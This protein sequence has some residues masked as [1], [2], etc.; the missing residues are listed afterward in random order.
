MDVIR[1][2]GENDLDARQQLQAELDSA[3]AERDGIEK[4]LA[5]DAERIA[6]I[7]VSLDSMTAAVWRD[8][9][10][11]QQRAKRHDVW[12]AALKLEWLGSWQFPAIGILLIVAISSTMALHT[13]GPI[14]STFLYA[15]FLLAGY[16]TA[17]DQCLTQLKKA[18]R[19]YLGDDGRD[20]RFVAF[21]H[22]ESGLHHPL[23]G[24]DGP[25]RNGSFEDRAWKIPGVR[26]DEALKEIFIEVIDDRHANVLLTRF[27]DKKPTLV[28]ADLENPF[29]RAYG[30][31]FQ[32]AL[33][34]QMPSVAAK[35]E[36][37][38]QT[39]VRMGE[40]KKLAERVGAI[41]RELR[42]LDGTQAVMSNMPVSL[43]VRNKLLGQTVFFRMGDA[44][45]GRG[46][47]LF[48][49]AGFDVN[50][51]VETIARASAAT[52]IPFSFSSQKIGYVG[53]GAAQVARTFE[54]A[55][56]ARSII[57]IEDGDRLFNNT[58]ATGFEP[59]RREVQQ[60]FLQQ[61]DALED[62]ADVWLIAAVHDR[63]AI[64][65]TVLAHFGTLI[66]LTPHA[67]SEQE[68]ASEAVPDRP[69]FDESVAI[70]EE[71]GEKVRILSAM[72]A[73]VET[74]ERQG[75]TVP[76][77]VLVAGPSVNARN[78]AIHSLVA[79]S[80]LTLVQGS[81]LDLDAATAQA[82]AAL[83][84]IVLLDIPEFADPGS[85]AHLCVFIDELNSTKTPVFILATA[86]KAT[87][88]EQE[89]RA[90]FGD[91][92]EIPGLDAS[93]R[94][95][96]LLELISGKPVEFDISE[97][98]ESFE[99]ETEGMSEERLREYV[100]DAIGR[101]AMRAISLGKPDRVSVSLRDFGAAGEP[102]YAESR[103]QTAA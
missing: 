58:G 9:F 18:R 16:V 87:D 56:R 84:A 45:V 61:W 14:F 96:K 77:G 12:M 30:V 74:M 80:G 91:V 95:E 31:F 38:R 89:L 68:P 101:A 55:R 44:S 22:S 59:M 62:R 97:H 13:F 52:Y 54:S 39:V 10:L 17:R 49:Q 47:M 94:R 85:I 92:I 81:M 5:A 24:F 26:D 36:E 43:T 21:T 60:A 15:V 57:F 78:A 51:I 40:R 3:R 46:L 27:P 28:H 37:F 103:P 100:E 90:R 75:I 33:E 35:A 82:R 70:P 71:A 41:E 86:R 11:Q 67:R 50:E 64:D 69:L 93:T 99:R 23:I 42:E 7:R 98:L 76:R 34:R 19:S 29:I 2:Q 88:V 63:E 20:I 66:D 8:V 25:R 72:F 32:R 1:M 83:P 65:Q 4:A 73:H 48:A 6:A 53:Q 102:E 79:Q